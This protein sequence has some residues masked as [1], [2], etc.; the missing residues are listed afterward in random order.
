ME[1]RKAVPPP[2][3]IAA[4]VRRF[5]EKARRHQKID[6]NP[7]PVLAA[8]TQSNKRPRVPLIGRPPEIRNRRPKIL[9]HTRTVVLME[10]S[11]RKEHIRVPGVGRGPVLMH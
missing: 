4:P 9:L 11:A 10:K 1:K 6:S 7:R 3:L 5:L 2:T 8:Q